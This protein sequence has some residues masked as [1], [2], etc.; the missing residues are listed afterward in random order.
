MGKSGVIF[1]QIDQEYVY[2]YTFPHSVLN[3]TSENN[4]LRA[5][6]NR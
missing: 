3:V 4:R 1:V 2:S 5:K 6:L